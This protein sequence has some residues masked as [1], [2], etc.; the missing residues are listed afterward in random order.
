MSRFNVSGSHAAGSFR[1]SI[2]RWHAGRA[3]WIAA[4]LVGGLAPVASQA[5]SMQSISEKLTQL[6]NSL[7]AFATNTAAQFVTVIAKLDTIIARVSE[8]AT[9]KALATALALK[10]VSVPV[11][12]NVTNVGSTATTVISHL[13]SGDGSTVA[14]DTATLAP[15]RTGGVGAGPFAPSF[16]PRGVWCNFEPAVAGAQLRG[17]LTIYHNSELVTIVQT[18]AR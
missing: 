12:Y 11:V 4:A 9:P 7:N 2:P 13:M 15:N 5:Q 14:S 17:A 6:Q 3:A 1:R 10:P 18:D 16:D 8:P